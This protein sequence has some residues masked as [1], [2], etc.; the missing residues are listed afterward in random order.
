MPVISLDYDGTYTAHPDFWLKAIEL[1]KS[2]GIDFIV[3]TM[4]TQEELISVCPLLKAAVSKIVPTHRNA[5]KAFCQAFNIKVDIWIDDIPEFIS[6]D[7][8]GAKSIDEIAKGM[9][10]LK[11]LG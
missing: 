1:G 6:I 10:A 8:A 3:V 5:K 11:N 2:M 7:A 4:R 9:L